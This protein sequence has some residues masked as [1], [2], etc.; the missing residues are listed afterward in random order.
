MSSLIG[1]GFP[2]LKCLLPEYSYPS[3]PGND[4]MKRGVRKGIPFHLLVRPARFELATS[5]FVVWRSIQ[6]S[7]GRI[8]HQNFS[9]NQQLI[10]RP[11]IQAA[12]N[13]N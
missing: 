3:L 13:R 11:A 7:H 10:A 1:Y 6:L 2:V 9:D 8:L 12:E 4:E 5:R